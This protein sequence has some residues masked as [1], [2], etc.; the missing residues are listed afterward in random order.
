L[1]L[2]AVLGVAGAGLWF[3]ATGRADLLAAAGVPILAPP[4]A[5]SPPKPTAPAGAPASTPPA[6]AAAPPA[7][8]PPAPAA[9]PPPPPPPPAPAPAPSAAAPGPSAPVAAASAS[10]SGKP[11]PANPETSSR[12]APP[13]I[14][15]AVPAP[16]SRSAANRPAAPAPS[17]DPA[18]KEHKESDKEKLLG[19]FAEA[20]AAAEPPPTVRVESTP[21]LRVRM[22]DK[23]LG[24]TPLTVTVPPPG[25]TVEIELFDPGL[26]L[27]RT[28]QLELK[29]G[30]NGVHKVLIP[31]GTLEF[32]I[33][34]GVAVTIDG[35][36]AGTAPLD[37]V[38]LY[39]GR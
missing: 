14:A 26:G 16:A 2:L 27:T 19:A 37:P 36:S 9:V 35:K 21:K 23:V 1:V 29:Q 39:E 4:A 12:P 22:G 32:S 6:A 38:Q 17:D 24:T 15:A 25:G 13:P 8:A 11:T 3:W 30:D 20:R 34:E 33:Q 28:E 5:S 7:S 10:R 18:P 31:K